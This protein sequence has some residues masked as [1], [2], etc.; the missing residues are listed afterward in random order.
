MRLSFPHP[1]LVWRGHVESTGYLIIIWVNTKGLRAGEQGDQADVFN[2]SRI[3]HT[4]VF[5]LK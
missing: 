5:T 1:L 4:P 2:K 3:D